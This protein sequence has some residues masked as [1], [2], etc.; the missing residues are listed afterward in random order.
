MKVVAFLSLILTASAACAGERFVWASAQD[1][2]FDDATKWLVA[3]APAERAPGA[4]RDDVDLQV[5]K[6]A[7]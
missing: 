7:R 2:D 4:A 1:G 6:E 3:D 5:S